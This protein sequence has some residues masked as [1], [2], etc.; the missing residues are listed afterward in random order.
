MERTERTRREL[1]ENSE[2]TVP[3]VPLE[4]PALSKIFGENFA[5]TSAVDHSIVREVQPMITENYCQ[6]VLT[7]YPEYITKEQM[8]RICHISKKTCSFLL[9]S[10]LIPNIDSGK[11]TRRFMDYLLVLQEQK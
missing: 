5:P 2:R 8:Y 11:K 3:H 9:E 4:L 1:G 7:K 10:G 6:E